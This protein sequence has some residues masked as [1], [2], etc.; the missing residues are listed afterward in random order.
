MRKWFLYF[1]LLLS[2]HNGRAAE[3]APKTNA[4]L[5]TITS[6]YVHSWYNF[7]VISGKKIGDTERLTFKPQRGYATVAIF[8]ASWCIPCQV[9]IRNIIELQEKYE[10]RH[11][12]F[13]YIFAHDTEADA[14]GFVKAYQIKGYNILANVEL[15][16]NFHQPDLP[17]IYL[18]DRYGWLTWRKLSVQ[19]KDIIELDRFL[20]LHTAL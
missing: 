14:A 18:G 3:P 4:I 6:R 17:T 5:D 10:K 19:Q 12:T 7:P 16:N 20:E 13:V 15:M 11:T 2:A 9:L 8:L 1:I